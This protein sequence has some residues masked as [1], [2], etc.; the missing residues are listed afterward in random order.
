MLR[1][2]HIKRVRKPSDRRLLAQCSDRI[3]RLKLALG[4]NV[5]QRAHHVRPISRTLHRLSATCLLGVQ[6]SDDNISAQITSGNCLRLRCCVT[7]TRSCTLQCWVQ[8]G[9]PD[10]P[11]KP[12]T[13]DSHGRVVLERLIAREVEITLVLECADEHLSGDAFLQIIRALLDA[14]T[15]TPF[16]REITLLTHA[17]RTVSPANFANLIGHRRHAISIT[18][19]RSARN[20]ASSAHLHERLFKNRATADRLADNARTGKRGQH[21]TGETE[22]S[23]VI[24]IHAPDVFTDGAQP[25]RH[26]VIVQQTNRLTDGIGSTDQRVS[27]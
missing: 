22:S 11:A 3:L 8:H 24:L 5:L 20:F 27:R 2:S 25:L 4:A 13:S 10:H 1:S 26:A 6:H 17:Q 7:G 15:D 14:S 23:T 12:K 16:A 9:L 19:D 21:I 18:D